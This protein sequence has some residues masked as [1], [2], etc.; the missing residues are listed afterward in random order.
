MK[1]LIETRAGWAAFHGE[2][3][4]GQIGNSIMS[5]PIEL[6]DALDI[7]ILVLNRD[8][9]V[10]G[11][12]QAA[13]DVLGLVPSDMGG[14]ARGLSAL[15]G[16]RNLDDFCSHVI[17]AGNSSRHDLQY[18]DQSFVVRIAP[19]GQSDPTNSGTVL[20]FANVTAFRASLDRAIYEREYTKAILNAA[21]DP[22]VVL[23]AD[24]RVQTAN[25]AFFAYFRVSRETIQNLPF[26]TLGNR[27]FDR[28]DLRKQ[29]TEMVAGHSDSQPLEI[30]HDFPGSGRRTLVLNARPFSLPGSGHLILLSLQDITERRRSEEQI[31]I[32]ARE[33]EHRAKN[34]LATV[35]AMVRLTQSDTA[36]GLK[37]AI[38]GRIQAL[39]NVHR[40]FVESQWM[41]AEIGS[42]VTDELA[43]Y[44][45][46]GEGHVQI[47]GPKVLLEPSVA[48]AIALSLHELATNAAKYGALSAPDGKIHV[49]WS[50]PA[51][52][53]LL[54]RWTE[55]GGP[56][57]KPPTRQGFGTRA[58]ESMIRGQLKG[59]VRLDWRI[60]GLACEIALPT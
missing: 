3:E 43:V 32:L 28:A 18:G 6:L 50:R 48:Q 44:S 26:T 13:A 47:G 29:L 39:A 23:S 16:L 55:T 27:A 4:N 14:S 58:I 24:L 45:Q 54:L 1:S 41:G 20:S 52:G 5:D 19:F 30:D 37:H 31:A 33:A 49:E 12:N 22:L 11:F 8:L 15:T 2:C 25:R 9:A 36:K 53:R 42:L 59:D 17:A 56:A 60:E 21:A 46:V 35:Q 7:P 10:V 34:V 51:E 38:E 40:L 57:V